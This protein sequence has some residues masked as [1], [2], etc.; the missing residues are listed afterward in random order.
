[1]TFIKEGHFNSM[2]KVTLVTDYDLLYVIG[3][4]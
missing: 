4:S 2:K 3:F 1:M